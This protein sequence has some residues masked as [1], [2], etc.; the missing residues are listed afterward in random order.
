MR[1]SQTNYENIQNYYKTP[2][3]IVIFE[4]RNLNE[5]KEQPRYKNK[6][7]FYSKHTF[8]VKIN[9]GDDKVIFLFVINNIY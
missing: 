4:N 1:Q 2:I 7:F 9:L 3:I 8:N 6:Y 5:I